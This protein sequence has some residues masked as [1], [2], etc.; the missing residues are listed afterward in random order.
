MSMF[1]VQ[2]QTVQA[3]VPGDDRGFSLTFRND[4]DDVA[5]SILEITLPDGE[6]I[7]LTFN[8]RG[9]LIEQTFVEAAQAEEG[10][11]VQQDEHPSQTAYDGPPAPL[12]DYDPSTDPGNF[13]L[14]NQPPVGHP[15][16]APA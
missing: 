3:I 10:D 14:P 7:I 15:Q 8:T 2:P 9:A 12:T 11:A 16:K 5:K 6:R 1:A 4:A 13:D